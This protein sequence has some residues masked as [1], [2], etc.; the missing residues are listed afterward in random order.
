[1]GSGCDHD[2]LSLELPSLPESRGRFCFEK[3]HE[4]LRAPSEVFIQKSPFTE[5]IILTYL[6]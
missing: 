1:M 5:A 2:V 4:L 3:M 6:V